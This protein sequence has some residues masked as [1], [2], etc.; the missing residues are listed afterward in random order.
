[1]SN[2]YFNGGSVPAP[3]A[4]GAS[5]AIR[6]EFAAVA[7]G[8]DKLPVLDVTTANKIVAIN[9]AGTGMTTITS[10]SGFALTNPTISGGTANNM[11]IG[12]S[13]PSSGAFTTMTAATVAVSG[14]AINNT[15]IGASAPSTGVFTSITAG[16]ATL[17][18]GSIDGTSIGSSVPSTGA[19]TS[20][21]AGGS[22]VI[23]EGG[24]QTLTGKTINLANNTFVATSAQLAAAVSDET[25]SGALVFANSPALAGTP[26]APTAVSGT[27]NTQIATTAFV[28]AVAFSAALPGQTGNAGKVITTDGSV[29]SWSLI[30]PPMYFLSSF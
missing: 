27:S 15:T 24:T 7:A 16:L 19:F 28:T 10:I 17:S 18:G 23:T 22:P 21:T 3:N 30:T 11:M 20:L 8:F 12:D 9:G 5:Q 13:V 4:P 25:G 14:G 26:T 1:M 29:A 2:S 6:V